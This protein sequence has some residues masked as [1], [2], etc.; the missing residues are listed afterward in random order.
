MLLSFFKEPNVFCTAV[1]V[2]F[3]KLKTGCVSSTDDI[4]EGIVTTVGAFW[5]KD[6]TESTKKALKAVTIVFAS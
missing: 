3:V 4:V 6:L 2:T 5:E 1:S